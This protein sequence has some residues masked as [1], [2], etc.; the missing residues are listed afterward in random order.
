[1]EKQLPE[2]LCAGLALPN[3]RTLT[4]GGVLTWGHRP[5][6]STSILLQGVQV[7]SDGSWEGNEAWEKRAEAVP[8]AARL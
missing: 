5:P 8:V 7:L 3:G 1:M 6:P 2:G 4:W